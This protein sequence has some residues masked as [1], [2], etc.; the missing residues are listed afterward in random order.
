MESSVSW[1][2][3][4]ILSERQQFGRNGR[5]GDIAQHRSDLASEEAISAPLNQ[6][7]HEGLGYSCIHMIHGHLIAIISRPTQ[8]Q[9]RKVARPNL[10]TTNLIGHVHQN[11]GALSCLRVLVGDIMAIF[12][13]PNIAEVLLHRRLD[14]NMSSVTPSNCASRSALPRVRLVCQSPA[15]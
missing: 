14:G 6:V 8:G 10:Q 4:I 15:W 13:V 1:L 12:V 9:F 11:L 2:Q 5:G 3:G 7:T